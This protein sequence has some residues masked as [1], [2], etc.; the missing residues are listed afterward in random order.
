[1][2][3]LLC[4]EATGMYTFKMKT[5]TQGCL[6]VEQLS[7]AALGDVKEKMP[8]RSR[9]V[10]LAGGDLVRCA[11]AR[12]LHSHCSRDSGSRRAGEGSR[13]LLPRGCQVES[14]VSAE[15]D[16]PEQIRSQ[17]P[18]HSQFLSPNYVTSPEEQSHRPFAASTAL[19]YPSFP[20]RPLATSSPLQTPSPRPHKCQHP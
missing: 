10:I 14:A 2:S 13:G 8:E 20:G 5:K 1:M 17:M 15:P 3:D 19:W 11:V 16:C 4:V 12:V 7:L 9:N 6:C 18:F